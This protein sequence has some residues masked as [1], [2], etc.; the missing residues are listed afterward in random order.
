MKA[1]SKSRKQKRRVRWSE[2]FHQFTGWSKDLTDALWYARVSVFTL[3]LLF[4]AL[5]IMNQGHDIIVSM[6]EHWRHAVLTYLLTAVLGLLNWYFPR[7]IFPRI[8][9]E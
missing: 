2:P 1:P 7:L 8:F 4:G 6:S 9:G 5:W 3:L